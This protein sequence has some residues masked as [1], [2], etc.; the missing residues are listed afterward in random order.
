MPDVTEDFGTDGGVA[1]VSPG[2]LDEPNAEFVGRAFEA[3][4]D[5]F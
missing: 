4:G 1:A 3:E 2:V 5:H